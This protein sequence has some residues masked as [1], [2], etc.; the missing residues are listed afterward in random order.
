M[1][2][3]IKPVNVGQI[4]AYLNTAGIPFMVEGD[5][6]TS[7]I[8]FSSLSHYRDNTVTWINAKKTDIELPKD[9][10]ICV[11]QEGVEIQAEAKIISPNSKA[12]FFSILERF[13]GTG[14]E[15]NEPAIGEGSVIGPN[16]RI[17]ENVKIGCNCSIRGEIYIGDGTTIG[18]NVVIRNRVEIGRNCTIQSLVAIGEDGYG[19]REDEG[20]IKTMNKHF[21]GVVIEDDVF[22]GGHTNIT[23]GTIDDTV[24]KKGTKIAQTTLIAHNDYIGENVAIV[25]AQLFGSVT[26]G[27]N[28]YVS[29]SII[30][31]QSKIG[32][33]SI[34]GMG[35]VVTQDVEDHK[36]V[37]GLPAKVVRDSRQQGKL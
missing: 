31:N 18:D 10:S 17:G 16:V 25:C 1:E 13:W 15:E 28:A 8:G 24:I 21:G 34:V 30:R 4:E 7:V 36:V 33:G 19:Y 22:I 9:I 2:K 20:H 27:D 6:E 12:T 23:R 32:S 29:S 3:T 37:M 26:V 14:E 5:R 35:S 11:V